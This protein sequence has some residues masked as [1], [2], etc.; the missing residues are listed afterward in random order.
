M[1]SEVLVLENTGTVKLVGK[2]PKEVEKLDSSCAAGR[3]L[4]AEERQGLLTVATW[5]A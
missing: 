2:S 4:A 3:R 1:E 5:H